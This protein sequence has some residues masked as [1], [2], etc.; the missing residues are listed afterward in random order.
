[1]DTPQ[2]AMLETVPIPFRFPNVHTRICRPSLN[3]ASLR[4]SQPWWSVEKHECAVLTFANELSHFS[5]FLLLG[6]SQADG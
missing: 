2:T 6:Y 4:I 5:K 1:M 3:F